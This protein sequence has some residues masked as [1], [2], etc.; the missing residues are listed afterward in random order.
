MSFIIIL[1][2]NH[3][4]FGAAKKTRTSTGLLPQRPQRCASTSSATAANK[5]DILLLKL[6]DRI[7]SFNKWLKKTKIK[8]LK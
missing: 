7:I 1:F 8:I 5:K 6:S 2:S 4:P 3:N